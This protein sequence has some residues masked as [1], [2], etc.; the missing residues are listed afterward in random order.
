MVQI[1]TKP[2]SGF[3]KKGT[4]LCSSFFFLARKKVP[5]FGRVYFELRT[6]WDSDNYLVYRRFFRLF[7]LSVSK[8]KWK[9]NETPFRN[10]IKKIFPYINDVRLSL[11]K[12]HIWDESPKWK[13]KQYYRVIRMVRR[14]DELVK[15]LRNC[16]TN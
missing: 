5:Y 11:K 12:N 15:I 9:F 3:S 16:I 13:N 7:I 2:V 6:S 10:T 14:C 1:I 8:L 4:V